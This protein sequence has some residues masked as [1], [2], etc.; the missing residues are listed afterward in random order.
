VART[1]NSRFSAPRSCSLPR[2]PGWRAASRDF[3]EHLVAQVFLIE[4]VTPMP[5]VSF[6]GQQGEMGCRTVSQREER[7][8]MSDEI[9]ERTPR[10]IPALSL[11]AIAVALLLGLAE[12]SGAIT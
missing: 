6:T 3:P 12:F 11:A 2:A 7:N 5:V 10:R 8:L 9:V 4:A 1:Q